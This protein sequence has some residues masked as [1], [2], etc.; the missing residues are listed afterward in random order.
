MRLTALAAVVLGGCAAP[1]LGQQAT[2]ENRV[3][4]T[5][6]A[7]IAAGDPDSLQAA[8]LLGDGDPPQRLRLIERAATA[9]PARTDIV[10]WQLQLC[11]RVAD[12]DPRPIEVRLHALDPGNGATW[13]AALERSARLK[14][15]AALQ[16][17]LVTISNSERF[18]VYWNA[19]IVH[20]ANAVIRT[21]AM[22]PK[23]AF[24]RAIGAAAAQTIPYKR[25][26]DFCR[27]RTLQQAAD[28]ATC[29][30]L[31]TVL[32]RG[33]TYLTQ[34]V[35]LYLARRVWPERSAEYLAA[36]DA[37]RL[38]QYRTQADDRLTTRRRLDNAWVQSR[39]ELLATHDTE[40]DVVLADLTGAGVNPDP[41]ED[42]RLG[43]WLPR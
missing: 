38:A 20:T 37:R 36:L 16:A 42:R 21:R 6:A 10:W 22:E 15:A 13:S 23:S 24:V 26:T 3:A 19:S 30:R 12:C 17:T 27:G 34:M 41:P 9:A 35:G 18:S 33:D 31:A 11:L 40:Q 2:F 14:D 29:R 1:D 4:R 28:L 25:M 8:A 43:K 7:L 39:L 32:G 5:E